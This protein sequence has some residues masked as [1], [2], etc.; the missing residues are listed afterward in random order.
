MRFL[1]GRLLAGDGRSV[2][3]GVRTLVIG[4]LPPPGG[5]KHARWRAVFREI[6]ALG[7]KT[8]PQRPAVQSVVLILV[9]FE[10]SNERSPSRPFSWKIKPRI[11]LPSVVVSYWAPEPFDTRAKDVSAPADQSSLFWNLSS[12]SRVMNRMTAL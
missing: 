3:L 5:A 10:P 11:G 9:I 4:H 12:E 1:T 8:A 6:A 2:R 7:R